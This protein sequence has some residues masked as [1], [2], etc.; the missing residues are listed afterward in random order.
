MHRLVAASALVAHLVFVGFTIIGGFLA[1]LMPWLFMPHVA[2]A[3]WGGRMAVT[4]AKCPLSRLENWGRERAGRPR[5]HADGFI[6]HYFEDRVYPA[7][8]KRRVEIGVGTLV[9]GSWF[10]LM[11]R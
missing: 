1:W 11:L 6:A 3:L 10:G 5:L 2:A 7:K 8:W 9:V 4:D